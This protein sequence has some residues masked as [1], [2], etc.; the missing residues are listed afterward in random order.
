MKPSESTHIG[1]DSLDISIILIMFLWALTLSGLKEFLPTAKNK[2]LLDGTKE[3]TPK[4]EKQG[5]MSF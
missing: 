5:G 2:T 4:K 3:S 1:N